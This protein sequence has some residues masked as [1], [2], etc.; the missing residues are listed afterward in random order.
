MIVVMSQYDENDIIEE[1]EDEKPILFNQTIIIEKWP[2]MKEGN[3]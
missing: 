1:E 3:C 2:L